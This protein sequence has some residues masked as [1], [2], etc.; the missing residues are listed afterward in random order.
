MPEEPFS[1][2]IVEIDGEN[3]KLKSKM[4]ESESVV[5][6]GGKAMSS[7]LTKVK[8]KTVEASDSFILLEKAAAATGLTWLGQIK[9]LG[10]FVVQL[11]RMAI[12]LRASTTAIQLETVALNRNTAAQVANT[13]V[14][15]GGGGRPVSRTTRGGGVMG[16]IGASA[17]GS[18][19]GR[20]W[21][22][23]GAQIAKVS[24]ALGKVG[25]VAVGSGAR[26]V[27]AAAAAAVSVGLLANKSIRL[28]N[29][30]RDNRRVAEDYAE[31]HKRL[32]KQ[33]DESTRK[34]QHAIRVAQAELKITRDRLS[35]VD[36]YR[37]RA[38]LAGTPA[39]VI[40]LNV[41]RMQIEDR[42]AR[43][44]K[45]RA[46]SEKLVAEHLERQR[47]A[48][49][50]QAQFVRLM[51]QDRRAQVA[52]S[53]ARGAARVA[54]LAQSG[55]GPGLA[56]HIQRLIYEMN[57]RTEYEKGVRAKVADMQA[58]RQLSPQSARDLL[59]QLFG[60]PSGGGI[61]SGNL[62]SIAEL[63]GART[64]SGVR[65]M[66]EYERQQLEL[67]RRIEQNTAKAASNRTGLGA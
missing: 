63:G 44:A 39:E 13:A 48:L 15:G 17:I 60:A 14:R 28:F 10:E 46:T 22:W 66:S 32:A 57:R 27:G 58:R 5:A 50:S 2:L 56:A 3:R 52:E 61:G 30:Y 8:T 34:R 23:A 54:Y 37:L 47:Q 31:T 41:R 19:I 36:A 64:I 42:R 53:R 20:G 24:A 11:G 40:A 7:Q 43:Q 18:A 1:R 35:A 59:A 21:S 49:E 25:R 4:R 38:E 16:F 55:Q 12:G 9:N 65:A 51:E 62:R 67:S 33:Y 45:E 6:K 29:V 26:I